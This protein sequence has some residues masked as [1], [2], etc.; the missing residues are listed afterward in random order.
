MKASTRQILQ[1]RTRNLVCELE[2]ARVASSGVAIDV[3]AIFA[4]V[5]SR[6]ETS[7]RCV[8]FSSSSITVH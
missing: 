7:A 8:G 1:F 4:V 2:A 3:A 6:T 5:G